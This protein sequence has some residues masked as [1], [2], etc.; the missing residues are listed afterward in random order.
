M[1]ICWFCLFVRSVAVAFAV[2]CCGVLSWLLCLLSCFFVLVLLLLFS[3]CCVCSCPCC[4]CFCLCF[5]VD[6]LLFGLFRIVVVAV[7]V[8]AVAVVVVTPPASSKNRLFIK[9]LLVK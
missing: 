9:V 3:F 5:F 8:A 4:C 2:V 6:C 1:L 7:V